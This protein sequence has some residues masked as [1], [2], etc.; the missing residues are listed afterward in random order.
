VSS[1]LGQ[2]VPGND[3]ASQGDSGPTSTRILITGGSG[4]IGTNLTQSYTTAGASV[5]NIDTAQ[6]HLTP[7]DGAWVPIDILDRAALIEAFRQFE[8]QHV[9]HLAART[10]LDERRDTAG[11][12]A[13]VE[14]V[15]NVIAAVR[16]IP[17]VERT[18]FASSRLVCRIG[19][20]PRHDTDYCPTTLYGASKVRGEELVRAVGDEFP[21]WAIVRP[22]SIWGPWFGVPY[23]LLFE[24]IERGA[25]LFRPLL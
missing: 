25:N 7:R 15:E 13:N 24:L 1:E 19:Y 23:R 17:S 9:V 6:P 4:F 3:R 10:D 5:L 12:R 18:V 2:R 8:P 11:Y 16:A 14:G 20:T 22:T 21:P